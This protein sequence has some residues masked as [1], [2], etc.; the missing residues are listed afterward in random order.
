MNFSCC[1]KKPRPPV[2]FD[3]GLTVNRQGKPALDC[4]FSTPNILGTAASVSADLSISSLIA[5]SVNLQYTLPVTDTWTFSAEALKQVNDYQFASSFSEHA[6][7]AVLSLCKGNHKFSVESFLR[8]IHPLIT[9]SGHKLV[10]SEQLR[11]V[12]LRTI[13]TSLVYRFTKDGVV[14]KSAANA[15]PIAGSKFSLLCDFSGLLGDVKMTKFDSSYQTHFPLWKDVFVWHSRIGMG[16]IAQL[17]HRANSQSH[18]TPIQD[19]FFLGGTNEE[20]SSFRGFAQRSMGPAGRRI[21][22]SGSQVRK[23]D[24]LFDHLGGD[25]YWTWDNS[26]SFPLYTKDNIDI[27][28]MVFGQIGSLVPTLTSRVLSDFARNVRVSVGA[29]V[30]VPVGGLGTMELSVG[31]PVFGTQ[32]SDTAQSLQIGIRISNS[33]R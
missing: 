17:M 4:Q 33:R 21:V 27:R 2:S 18:P 29:G 16:A 12:P 23:G 6:T 25:A 24:K 22:T 10:A 32:V 26:I 5:H 28:G 15:H 11:R 30:V 9:I 1:M 14:K 7:G 20:M 13:K 3:I 19:R 31:K 8:D